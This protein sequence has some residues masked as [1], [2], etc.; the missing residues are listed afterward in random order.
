MASRRAWLCWH[1]NIFTFC[2]FVGEF[3][4]S[5]SIPLVC[6]NFVFGVWADIN[7]WSES[8]KR[9]NIWVMVF[10]MNNRIIKSEFFTT[11]CLLV[12]IFSPFFFVPTNI[13]SI[14]NRKSFQLLETRKKEKQQTRQIIL[15]S[16][17]GNSKL[18]PRMLTNKKIRN[19]KP[20]SFIF[21][22]RLLRT[23]LPSF[24]P[25]PWG[26]NNSASHGSFCMVIGRFSLC[27]VKMPK[28]REN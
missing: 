14:F 10:N 3:L 25:T 17:K 2:L 23:F 15:K 19:R 16:R 22:P 1:G 12:C 5:L 7:E 4:L 9:H 26:I 21:R 20:V 18:F 8:P 11:G 24:A 28:S 27:H 6:F 13:L